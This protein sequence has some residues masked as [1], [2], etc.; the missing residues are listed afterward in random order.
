MVLKSRK[1]HT[2]VAIAS[3]AVDRITDMKGVLHTRH[4]GPAYWIRRTLKELYTPYKIISGLLPALVD[5]R[6]QKRGEHGNFRRVDPIHLRT[7]CTAEAFIVSTIE[8]EFPIEKLRLLRGI[9]AVDFQ[10]YARSVRASG[11]PFCVP[12]FIASRIAIAKVTV[13][14]LSCLEQKFIV[15]QKKRILIIT[16]GVS[17]FEVYRRGKHYNFIGDRVALSDTIGAGDTFLTAF[18]VEWLR[19]ENVSKSAMKAQ[20]VV[21]H[22]LEKKTKFF[23]S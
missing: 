21:E 6:L 2:I 12:S 15:S 4:G 9:I 13:H 17:G 7:L 19:T 10:G 23:N 5:I 8:N 3:F 16:H 11:K 18:V 22:F 1:Q 14:E 20:T